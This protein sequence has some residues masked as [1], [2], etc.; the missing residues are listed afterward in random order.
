MPVFSEEEQLLKSFLFFNSKTSLPDG[1]V[2]A[3]EEILEYH[4]LDNTSTFPGSMSFC[5]FLRSFFAR[6]ARSSFLVFLRTSLMSLPRRVSLKDRKLSVRQW[7]ELR[8]NGVDS[9]IQIHVS[10]LQGFFGDWIFLQKGDHLH[11]DHH[12]AYLQKNRFAFCLPAFQ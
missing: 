4:P 2:A 7:L 10:Y 3:E 5:Q 1:R 12:I 11:H 8:V 9:G 6:L